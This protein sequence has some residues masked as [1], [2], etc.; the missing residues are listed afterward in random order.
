M[1]YVVFYI[2]YGVYDCLLVTK[3]LDKAIKTCIENGNEIDGWKDDKR[4]FN[5]ERAFTKQHDDNDFKE[6]KRR[7][8]KMIG[9]A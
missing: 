7:I 4:V 1:I 9:E 5:F 6:A 3:D 2:D 8:E